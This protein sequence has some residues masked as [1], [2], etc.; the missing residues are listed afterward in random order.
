MQTTITLTDNKVTISGP[1]SEENNATYR[2]LGGKFDRGSSSWELPDNATTRAEVAQLFGAKS[3]EGDYLVPC[4]LDGVKG[5]SILQIGGYVLA[6]RRGRDYAVRL[7]EGVSLAAGSLPSSGGS[8]KNPSVNP[9][10]DT[11][12]RLRCRA[13]FADAH[14]L[15]P[16][17]DVAAPS[18]EI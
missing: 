18:I 6:S 4:S 15:Q 9:S 2:S 3:E 13:A 14:G 8:V 11:V 10:Q 5:S 1:Y 7:P 16:V 17:G 12:F